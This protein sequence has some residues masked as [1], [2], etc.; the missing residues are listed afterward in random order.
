MILRHLRGRSL[1]YGDAIVKR[2][3]GIPVTKL[4]MRRS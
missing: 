3:P 4:R 1:Q 2:D